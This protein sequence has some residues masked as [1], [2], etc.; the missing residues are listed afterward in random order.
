[1]MYEFQ[2]IPHSVN[3]PQW[4]K[5]LRFHFLHPVKKHSFK[6]WAWKLRRITTRVQNDTEGFLKPL[7][8]ALEN[9]KYVGEQLDP[10]PIGNLFLF[11]Y[12]GLIPHRDILGWVW[13]PAEMCLMVSDLLWKFDQK[14]KIPSRNCSECCKYW[15]WSCVTNLYVCV[16]VG[17]PLCVQVGQPQGV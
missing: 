14:G 6:F 8:G 10:I 16:Q 1:M 17:W 4:V 13:Y 2:V 3:T 11:C 15:D 12:R 5:T 9:N 7:K